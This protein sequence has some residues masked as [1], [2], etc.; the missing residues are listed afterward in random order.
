MKL[1]FS[2]GQ[3]TVPDKLALVIKSFNASAESAK[4][5][6]QTIDVEQTSIRITGST[7]N[8]AGTK[9]F[10]DAIMQNNLKIDNETITPKGDRHNFIMNLSLNAPGKGG[11]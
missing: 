4:L 11:K 6:I 5:D 8:E 9:R 10:R 7:I 1:G 3:Q 2:T